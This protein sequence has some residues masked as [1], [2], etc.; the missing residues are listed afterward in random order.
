MAHSNSGVSKGQ[1]IRLFS[2]PG[3]GI[4][5]CALAVGSALVWV[6]AA[7]RILL[8]GV[9]GALGAGALLVYPEVALALYVVVGDVKGDDRVAALLPVDWT[10][11]FGA[12]LLAGIVMNFLRR[13][14]LLPLPGVYLVFV[15]LVALMAASLLYTPA[16]GA[17]L[18]KLARFLTVTAIV[19][20][21][22]FSVL[23]TPEA[24]K[25]FL[26]GF[27]AAAFA[28]CA[29]SL[30]GLGGDARL[31]T[32]TDN[33]IG[34]GH[35]AAAAFLLIWLAC[36]PRWPFPRRICAYLLLA[37]PALA[38][39]GSG[40]RGSVVACGIVILLSTF[41]DRRLWFDLACLAAVGV[42]LSPFLNI[43]N[44]AVEYLVRPGGSRSLS[45]MLSF[46]S[47]LLAHGWALL[48]QHPL[49]GAGLA[50]FRY[51]SPN[52]V[53]YK[54]PHDIFLEIACELG[55][56]AALIAVAIFASA[57]REALRQ[58]RD[59]SAPHLL[60][61]QFAAALLV[62]GVINTL[63]TGDINSDRATWL[64]VSLVFVVR[65]LRFHSA[66]SRPGLLPVAGT[67][68]A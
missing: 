60:L 52:P 7:P 22:P 43:P 48:Q 63:N 9:I 51:S 67:S 27:G 59:R 37:V 20:V 29:W 55:I 26:A 5:V 61:S 1:G 16:F 23:G 3:A 64:F 4:F 18:E 36:V 68:P 46:R 40:S 13:K 66:E 21:A 33:T 2:W 30:A 38:L 28:I 39:V 58:L 25:R 8:T 6:G 19:I 54:W 49:V 65:A 57:L 17:G 34:L 12:V 42:A 44:A 56:P 47:D 35:I 14:P 10:L 11:A 32:P 62:T 41:F 50:G 15:P 53:V 24:M 45:A 31:V